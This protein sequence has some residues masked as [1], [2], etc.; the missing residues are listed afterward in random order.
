[1]QGR[2]QRFAVHA[3]AMISLWG[4]DDDVGSH[5]DFAKREAATS[6]S[7]VREDCLP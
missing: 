4:S 6:S 3:R 5:M 2:I 1:V 7:N